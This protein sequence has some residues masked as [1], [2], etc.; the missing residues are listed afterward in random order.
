MRVWHNNAGFSPSWYLSQIVVA[1]RETKVTTYFLSNRWFA[2]DEGDGKIDRIIPTSVEKDITKFHNLFLAKSSREMNDDHLWFSVAGRP[3]RSPF[4]RVQRLSCCLTLL[5]SMMLT[6]IMF[7]GRGDDFY[8]PEPIRFAGLKINPPISLPQLMIGIQSAAIILPVNL[9]IAFLFRNSRSGAQKKSIRKKL[10]PGS[11]VQPAKSEP[12]RHRGPKKEETFISDNPDTPSVWYPIARGRPVPIQKLRVVQSSLDV[13]VKESC[14]THDNAAHGQKS[15]LPWWGVFI[16]WLLVWSASFVAAFFT[17]LYTLSFGKAKAEA[18]ACTFVTSFVTDLFL[19]QPVK[20]VLVAVIFALYTKKPVEDKDPPP[21]PTGNDEEYVIYNEN[22]SPTK[23]KSGTSAT[24]WVRYFTINRAADYGTNPKF[25]VEVRSTSPP[26]E[27]VLAEARARSAEKRKRRAAVLE[28]LVFGLFVTVIMLTA[29]QEQS[30]LAFYM[31]QNVKEQI[32][33]E[34]FS[35]V[36]DIES[37]WSWL[38][39]ELIPTTRSAEWYNGRTLAADTVLQDMLTHPLDSVQLRQLRLKQGQLCETAK[40]L[41]HITP[42]CT[43]G[44]SKLTEDID[45]YTQGWIRENET[46][47]TTDPVLCTPTSPTPTSTVGTPTPP[48]PTSTM[49]TVTGA[50]CVSSLLTAE[51]LETPWKYNHDA[52]LINSFPYFGQ[53]GTYRAGGYNVPL[54]KT[55]AS[56]LRLA[57]FLQQRG[58]L[59]ERTRAVIVELILYNPHANLFSMVTLVVEFTNLGAAYRGGEV[60]T[61]RLMQQEAILLLA[62]RAVLAV[63]ILVFVIKEAER[64]FSRPMEYLKDFWSWVELL[65][66]AI[67]IATLGVYFNAQSII[68]KAAEQRASSSS[69]L[70]LY[71]SAVNW[72][73]VYT[74]LLAFL[75]CCGTLKFIRLLRFNSHVYALTMTIRKSARPVLLFTI[76]AGIILMAFT[77]M[78]NLLF[79]IKL[80][81]YKNILTSLTSLC[82]MMLGVFDF[83]AL[84]DGHYILGPLMFFS[85]QVMM[86]FILLSMFMAILMDV[87]AEESQDPNTDDLKMVAFIRETTSE[88]AEKANRTLSTVG[89][90]NVTK[91]AQVGTPDMDNSRKFSNVFEELAGKI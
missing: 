26:D 40:R 27:D 81:D 6:N 4:T 50:D 70:D 78:G 80:Q 13:D 60:V 16:G 42:L 7:F 2:I 46:F 8:P 75:I 30:P 44:F 62:L 52:S 56:G 9:L 61:L 32:M 91:T 68:D 5:Y 76:I 36:N 15:S 11:G 69:V 14:K 79:G 82:T 10:K 83:D 72:F 85:Y 77:Q 35:D 48:T 59:D 90:R 89:N 64:L 34:G 23:E 21:T 25:P 71:K 65:V 63:F 20:L 39:D 19:V 49:D 28:V 73:Q 88:A 53:H 55:R 45:D 37:F 29:Y 24:S 84:V 74:Y 47:D 31:T 86:Q 87:Y 33:G 67:G 58:W 51:E 41:Q 54:G 66:I 22:N 12:G 1:N 3:A 18:W 38:E 57:T 43:V 17:V